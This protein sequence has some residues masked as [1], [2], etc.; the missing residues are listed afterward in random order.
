MIKTPMCRMLFNR[1]IALLALLAT[2]SVMPAARGDGPSLLRMF[3]RGNHT[4]EADGSKSYQLTTED[5]PWMILAHTFVG[6]GSGERAERL[7]LEIRRELNLPAFVFEEDF[8]FSGEVNP[9]SAVQRAGGARNS[10]RM[11]Y[12]N[13]IRYKAHAVLVGEYDS[14]E[15]PRIDSDLERVKTASCAVFQDKKEMAAET[16][17]RNPVTAVKALHHRLAEKFADKER[18]PMGNAFLTRN[19]ML[20]EDFFQSPEVDSFVRS[21]NDDKPNSLLNCEGKYTVVVR[22]FTGFNTIVDGKKEKG[23]QPSGKRML[24]CGV[25]AH[26][27]V[28]LLRA[29]G[30]EAYEFH[31]RAQSLVTIG[32]FDSLGRE[33]PG[34]GFE[35]APEIQRVMNEYRAFNID[36]SLADHVKHQTT[37]GIPVKCV[38]EKFPFDVEPLPIAV[39]K[40]SK[41]SLYGAMS[42]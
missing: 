24:Q 42:R 1:S 3:Q 39:P 6:A 18:G 11:R 40:A 13:Q 33:L 17:F 27:M 12:Q 14:S 28:A 34:G 10:R 5:G 2:T 19:P 20:P 9:G 25:D 30:V 37:Q 26:K 23:F 8:D 32:S 35:Y 21:L 7:A 4:V 38:A 36:P 16:D 31:D 22:T 41:R 29:E 15:H